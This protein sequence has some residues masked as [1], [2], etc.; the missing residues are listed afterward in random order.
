MFTE[1]N[2]EIHLVS[3]FVS[4]KKNM[5]AQFRFAKLNLNNTRFLEQCPF[6]ESRAV[7]PESTAPHLEKT[8]LSRSAQT[9]SGAVLEAWSLG[10]FCRLSNSH[11]QLNWIDFVKKIGGK[12]PHNTVREWD[13]HANTNTKQKSL[14]EVVAAK[15]HYKLLCHRTAQNPGKT[16]FSWRQWGIIMFNR[17]KHVANNSSLVTTAIFK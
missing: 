9:P 4:L 12:F 14:L 8:K 17:Y 16:S 15:G 11:K 10:S 1:K 5:T 2:Q 13:N 6:G 3:T 7:L